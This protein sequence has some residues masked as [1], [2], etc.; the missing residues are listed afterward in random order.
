MTILRSR[1]IED[2]KVAGLS[3]GTQINYVCAVR[4]LAAHY[5][6]SPDQLTEAEVRAYLL[7]LRDR[8]AHGTFK[9]NHGGVQFFYL[10]TL[11]REWPLFLKKESAR[12]SKDASPASWRTPRFARF[13]AA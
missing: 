5:Q 1:M 9:A 8:G 2:M 11:G 7:A 6:R 10:R 12:R 3:K 4:R 13:L